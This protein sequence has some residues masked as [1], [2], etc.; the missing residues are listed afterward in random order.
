MPR[1]T[2]LDAARA[3]AMLLVVATHGALAFMV[4]P[5]G[6]AIQ[7]RS[8]HL[9]VD[10]YVWI[11]RAFA[12]PTF[13]WLSGYFSR[14]VMQGGLRGFVRHRATRILLPLAI[15]LVPISLVLGALWDW[16]REVGARASVAANIPKLK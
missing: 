15:A 10:L 3:I 1:D 13:F 4:T 14:A 6:W 7:D 12:M 9:G 5:I 8:R 2:G 16:G 11:V